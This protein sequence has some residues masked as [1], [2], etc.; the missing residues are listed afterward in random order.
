VRD[1]D[2]VPLGP[3]ARFSN[4]VLFETVPSLLTDF[5]LWTLVELELSAAGML[6]ERVWVW[7]SVVVVEL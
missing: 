3:L 4:L 2:F 6:E 1:F 5:S 7:V